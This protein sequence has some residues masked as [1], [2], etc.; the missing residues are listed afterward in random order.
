MSQFL[1]VGIDKYVIELLMSILFKI[2]TSQTKSQYSQSVCF[3]FDEFL[4]E[5]I[6]S[7]IMNFH[8]TKHFRFQYY[9]VK[10]FL[11]FNEENLQLPEMVLTKE[12]NRNFFKYMNVLMPQVYKVFFQ[13]KLPRVLPIMK[14]YLQIA[15]E[16]KI[17]DFLLLE[18]HTIIRLH[19]FTHEFYILP[20][21]LTPIIFHQ[22]S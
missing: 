17:G 8:N 1:G 18:E 14:E 22:N 20:A 15:Q 5:S 21:F 19:G 10:M 11:F 3:K 6:H 4:D 9:L 12:I 7:Q 2:S 13:A 16:K